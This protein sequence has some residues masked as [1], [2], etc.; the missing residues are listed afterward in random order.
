ME[1]AEENETYEGSDEDDDIKEHPESKWA[2]ASWASQTV[3]RQIWILVWP[4]IELSFS[5]PSDLLLLLLL[6]LLYKHLSFVAI[7]A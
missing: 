7:T 2:S 1:P 6:L 4:C 5:Y 3:A